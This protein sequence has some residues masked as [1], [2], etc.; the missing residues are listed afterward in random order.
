MIRP[1]YGLKPKYYEDLLGMRTNRAL[2]RGT[3]LSFEALEKGAILFLT[4][5]ENTEEL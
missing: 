3:P 4:N 1:G 5:N 2:E